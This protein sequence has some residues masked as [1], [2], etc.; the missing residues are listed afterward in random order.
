MMNFANFCHNSTIS[1]SYFVEDILDKAPFASLPI[2]PVNPLEL[3]GCDANP[4]AVENPSVFLKY[5]CPECDY[6]NRNISSGTNQFW[7]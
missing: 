2:E 5:C 6:N 1:S 7:S 4:W 3:E